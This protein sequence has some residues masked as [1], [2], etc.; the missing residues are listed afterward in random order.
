MVMDNSERKIDKK[1]LS[2]L[3][4][5][6]ENLEG[7]CGFF[8]DDEEDVD[9]KFWVYIILD[10]D[11]IEDHPTKPGFVANRYRLGVK[12][13]I[14]KYLGLDVHVGSTSRKCT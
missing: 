5:F 1:T 7:I 2:L 13:E 4:S 11:K 12:E 9:H 14:R 3:T 10:L 6:M 8:I